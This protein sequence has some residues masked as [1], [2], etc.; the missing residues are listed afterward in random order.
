L[1]SQKL[2]STFQAQKDLPIQLLQTT[3][4]LRA[5]IVI[6]SFGDSKG[7]SNQ[8]FDLDLLYDAAAV[9][10]TVE[11]PLRY[12]KL[13]EIN[14]IFKPDPKSGPVL[15]SVFFVLAILAS[16]PVLLGTVRALHS[17]L[18]WYID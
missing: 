4:P 5:T 16:V 1:D 13:P 3:K 17:N 10:P 18:V 6:G 2:I 15:I 7:L 8:V 11:A 14:H 12:G 9:K